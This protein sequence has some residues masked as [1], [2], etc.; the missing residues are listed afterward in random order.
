MVA[1]QLPAVKLEHQIIRCVV[2]GI[3]LL[4]HDFS[5]KIE[6]RLTK[7]WPEDQIGQH[8]RGDLHVLIEN[9]RLI[10]RMLARGICVERS[11]K[12]LECER[13]ILRR[14]RRRALEHHVLE[15]VRDA[16]DLRSLVQ[17]RSAHPR[18]QSNRPHSRHVLREYGQSVGQD[19]AAKSYFIL[20]R[21]CTHSRLRP[22]PL[23][24]ERL[25]GRRGRSSRR[26][27]LS[28]SPSSEDSAGALSPLRA[29][30]WKG[31]APSA[32]S[33][34]GT[35]AFIERRRRPRS[36]RS[37][38]FTLTRSPLF[39]TSSVFSVRPCLSSEMCTRPSV[40]GMISTKAPNAVVLLTVP[41][42]VSPITGSAVSALT[43]AFA[44]SIASPPTA[45]IV[46]RPVSSTVISAPVSS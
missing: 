30:A 15:H 18:P 12:G 21:E 6:I 39:T 31:D 14:A 43:I 25:R 33:G 35:S 29:S 5:F 2:D 44:R 28:L 3:D 41:S 26:L 16:H 45:A 8:I 9:A 40:P 13:E 11:A 32:A 20:R 37:R 4:E 1:P 38:S 17:C 34:F 24:G 23:R 42:Y 19:G 27:E 36:S 7:Q 22:P 46:T 10:C